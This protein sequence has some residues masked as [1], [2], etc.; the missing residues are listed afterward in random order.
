M[1]RPVVGGLVAHVERE[2]LLLV[3]AG[4]A[5]IES[6]VLEDKGAFREPGGLRHFVDQH[7]FGEGGG[8]VLL[9][10]AVE[11]L[12]EFVLL[13]PGEHAERAGEAVTK[14]V[15]RR[16]GFAFRSTR[17][18]GELSVSLIG[19]NLSLRGHE[20][21]KNLSARVMPRERRIAWRRN[22][23]EGVLGVPLRKH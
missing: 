10:Q 5:V 23:E 16:N 15:H 2:L 14:I 19:C 21:L 13:F 20:E 18:R 17:P 8:L 4:H 3:A 7:G 6:G 9:A 1:K 11:Q 22:G 12:V